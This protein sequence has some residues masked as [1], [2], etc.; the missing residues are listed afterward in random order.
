MKS[1]STLAKLASPL[2]LVTTLSFYVASRAGGGVNAAPAAAA[3]T[4]V[5]PTTEFPFGG[6]NIGRGQTASIIAILLPD[7]TG[8]DQRPVEAEL[9]F[10]DWDGNL[11][12]SETKTI[13]PGQASSFDIRAGLGPPQKGELIPCVKVL[14]DPSD[15]RAGRI[16]ATLEVWDTATGKAQLVLNSATTNFHNYFAASG[17]GV[18][19]FG[20]NN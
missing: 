10:H 9:M 17:D 14:V 20:Q 1:I 13:L 7:T 16:V 12:A 3:Q 6:I 5:T 8:R 18:V 19:R 4:E 11:L 15:P 2:L